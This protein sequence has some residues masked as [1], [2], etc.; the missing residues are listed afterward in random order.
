MK[1]FTFGSCFAASVADQLCRIFP[2]NYERVS[3][4]QHNRIDQFVGAYI[5]ETSEPVFSMDIIVSPIPKV[6]SVFANQYDDVG[7]GRSLPYGLQPDILTHPITTIKGGCVDLVLIDPFADILFRLNR[8]LGTKKYMY[9]HPSQFNSIE[10]DYEPIST[11]LSPKGAAIGYVDL[12]NHIRKYSPDAK[13]VFMNFPMNLRGKQDLTERT[14]AF[15]DAVHSIERA[16]NLL[17]VDL[18]DIRIC[19]SN[20]IGDPYHFTSRRYRQYAYMIHGM[21]EAR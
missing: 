20:P 4:V 3:T 8:I 12:L 16:H 14:Y 2:A 17:S 7:L 6:A 10:T 19:D 15:E 13:A 21:L 18:F 9:F 5:H 1:I 11:F